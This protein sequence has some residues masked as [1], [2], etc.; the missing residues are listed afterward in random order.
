MNNIYN[1]YTR[2]PRNDY[3]FYNT[4]YNH[5]QYNM[6]SPT[7]E[8]N[9]LLDEDNTLVPE[10]QLESPNTFS[11]RIIKILGI[12]SIIRRV[13]AATPSNNPRYV[14]IIHCVHLAHHHYSVKY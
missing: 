11:Q 13:D 5:D 14:I 3:A 12:R 2:Q 10:T 4:T 7:A 9:H 6:T 1:Y 8:D